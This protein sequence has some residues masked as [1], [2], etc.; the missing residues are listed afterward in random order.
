MRERRYRPYTSKYVLLFLAAASF[1]TVLLGLLMVVDQANFNKKAAATE[2]VITDAYVRRKGGRS[3]G[4]RYVCNAYLEYTV[5]GVTYNCT[6][7]NFDRSYGYISK[8]DYFGRIVTLM[9]DPDDPSDARYADKR[10]VGVPLMIAGAAM[11]GMFAFFYRKN[12]YYEKLIKNGAVLDAVVVDI[13]HKTVVH[14]YRSRSRGAFGTRGG[15]NYTDEDNYRIIVCEWENPLT[16]QKY[17]FRSRRIKEFVEPYVGQTVRVYAD[18]Q[19]YEKYFVDVDDLLAK[20]FTNGKS[21]AF[22]YENTSK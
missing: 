17:V 22:S 15:T 18:P 10:G 6:I 11:A 20:P 19:N 5:N 3:S 9:Y 1:F 14:Y 13:E 4:R 2:A 12:G 21:K 8:S 7:R 16:G